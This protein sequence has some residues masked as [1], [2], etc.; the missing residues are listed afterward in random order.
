MPKHFGLYQTT[1]VIHK[2]NYSTI[3]LAR[4]IKT[5]EVVA[6]KLFPRNSLQHQH[7]LQRAEEEI[8][9][10]EIAKCK[11][12]AKIKNIVYQPDS[13]IIVMKYYPNGNLFDF[14]SRGGPISESYSLNIILQI[15]QA[16][17]FLHKR[18]ISHRDIK[19][20]N[21]VFSE[22][23]KPNLIDFGLSTQTLYQEFE[24]RST[25][26][27]TFE[28]IAPEILS[29]KEYNP[30]KVDVWSLGICAF[31]MVT[32]RYPWAQTQNVKELFQQIRG[33]DICLAGVPDK[34]AKI[35]SMMLV[36]NPQERASIDE[37][38]FEIEKLKT[39]E[40]S[41]Q[42]PIKILKPQPK[43]AKT[44]ILFAKNSRKFQKRFNSY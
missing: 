6:C 36:R 16:I 4:H 13:I 32:G 40:R 18:G 2:S 33:T 39:S 27:G 20:E 42:K 22:N 1:K 41:Y 8:R 29:H 25:I 10:A 23:F 34:I 21:I 43:N 26:C 31:I 38:I 19:L 3:F 30:K 35:I 15:A 9:I 44:D 11:G 28:Y 37:V 17:S 12:I 7:I 14:F 24:M 5:K